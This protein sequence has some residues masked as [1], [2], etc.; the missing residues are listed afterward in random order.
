M[1]KTS[2]DKVTLVRWDEQ[3]QSQR[4]GVVALQPNQVPDVF[5]RAGSRH[6]GVRVE[7]VLGQVVARVPSLK[8]ASQ[9][10]CRPERIL[11]SLRQNESKDPRSGRFDLWSELLRHHTEPSSENQLRAAPQARG[12]RVSATAPV[13]L[14]A[15]CAAWRLSPGSEGSGGDSSDPCRPSDRRHPCIPG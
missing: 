5:R 6:A 11:A 1:H 8:F 10:R 2:Q 13:P 7:G 3:G 4:L 14:W 12:S 9:M 15:C